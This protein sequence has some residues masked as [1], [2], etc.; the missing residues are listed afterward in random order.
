MEDLNSSLLDQDEISHNFSSSK[1]TLIEFDFLYYIIISRYAYA[2]ICICIHMQN[3]LKYIKYVVTEVV[4]G[5][6]AQDIPERS[7]KVEIHFTSSLKK[8]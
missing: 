4:Y 3:M 1:Y 7:V 8:C 5:R 6:Y 2:Y